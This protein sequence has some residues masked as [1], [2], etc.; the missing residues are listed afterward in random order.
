MCLQC[1]WPAHLLREKC[2]LSSEGPTK[3][4]SQAKLTLVS[5]PFCRIY[6]PILYSFYFQVS[7]CI[8]YIKHNTKFI[9]PSGFSLWCLL[10]FA[11]LFSKSV[12]KFLLSSLLYSVLCTTDTC[13]PSSLFLTFRSSTKSSQTCILPFPPQKKLST[14][15]SNSSAILLFLNSLSMLLRTDHNHLPSAVTETTV[16]ASD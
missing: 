10:F 12:L 16:N 15:L 14:A 13:L 5:T 9:I 11:F 1:Q 7:L 3:C 2:S 8:N 4:F 6:F